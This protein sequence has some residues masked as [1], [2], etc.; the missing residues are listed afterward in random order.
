[1]TRLPNSSASNCLP[2]RKNISNGVSKPESPCARCSTCKAKGALYYAQLLLEQ[3][4]ARRAIAVLEDRTVGPLALLQKGSEAARR[5]GFAEEAYKAALRAYVTVSPP[6]REKAVGVMDAFERTLASGDEEAGRQQLTRIYVALGLV[7]QKQVQ[8]LS[9]AGRSDE[10]SEVAALFEDF[11]SR[12]N[13]GSDSSDWTVLNWLAQ[14]N[15]QLALG[16][17]ESN[18]QSEEATYYFEQ[19]ADA[20]RSI[21]DAAA[22]DPQFAPNATALLGVKK[23]LADCLRGMGDYAEAVQFYAEVLQKKPNLLDVQ[24]AAATTLQEQGVTERDIKVI[25]QAIR[26]AM[27]QA[28]QKNLIWGWLRM[29]ALADHS[30]RKIQQSGDAQSPEMKQRLAKY[31]DLFFEARYRVAEAR[32]L[33][34]RIST[35]TE[36]AKHLRS[37][38]QNIQSMKQLYPDLGGERRKAAYEKLLQNIEAESKR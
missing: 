10:A 3:G 1:M 14:T 5:E 18:P 19:A 22:K 28:N 31:E 38:R 33:A 27:P 16:L 2:G 8:Q 24:Q 11:L 26:G 35:G 30:V 21:L 23:Q 34:G 20:Y 36:K 7:L 12:V 37:A 25:D 32:Y 29:A 17:R 9:G 4:D 15:Y 6:Q 13:Q